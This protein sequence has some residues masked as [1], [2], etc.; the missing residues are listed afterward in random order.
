[1]EQSIISLLIAIIA[2]VGSLW[3][4]YLINRFSK[5][6]TLAE[7]KKLE[8]ESINIEMDAAQKI[9][10]ELKQELERQKEKLTELTV[11][12]D[13][14][15]KNETSHLYEKIRLESK[16]QKLVEENAFLQK[17]IEENKITYT[18]EIALLNVQI[19]KLEEELSKYKNSK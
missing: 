19:K 13:I 7:T 11:E 8:A 14:L 15:K 16:I 6:K 17:Q 18:T 12:I 3:N 10:Q 2:V 1:M 9:I 5:K 4:S